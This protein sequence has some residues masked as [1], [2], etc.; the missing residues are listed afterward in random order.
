MKY[1]NLKILGAGGFGTVYLAID[2][3][4]NK[5]SVKYIPEDKAHFI[6]REIAILEKIKGIKHVPQ[7]VEYFKYQNE[8]RI[9]LQYIEGVTLH[10]FMQCAI[11]AKQ[12]IPKYIIIKL[13]LTMFEIIKNLHAKNIVHRD[14][15]LENILFNNT[16]IQLIDFGFACEIESA[17]IARCIATKAGTTMYMAPEVLNGMFAEN[18]EILK[19][20]DIWATGILFYFI[21][22]QR[23]PFKEKLASEEFYKP[24][25]K[26]INSIIDD[27]LNFSYYQRP[28]A[29]QLYSRILKL[30]YLD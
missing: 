9:V 12:M 1:R 29:D 20:S 28:T 21:V 24:D 11:E 22:N 7:F 6:E 8:Y 10:R 14:I 27:M 15:K 2:K 4:G 5:Y 3:Y 18:F 23:F 25:Y 19:A 16:D 13:M 26:D 17:S 30:E